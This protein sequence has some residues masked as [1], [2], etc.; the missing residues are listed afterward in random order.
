[1]PDI[2]KSD[3]SIQKARRSQRRAFSFVGNTRQT[4]T[5][6]FG[7]AL[8]EKRQSLGLTQADLAE[9]TGMSRSYISEVECGRENIS[10]ERAEKLARA[11]N[12]NLTELIKE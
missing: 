4:I 12:S 7:V 9:I 10:L 6:R 2:N 3:S 1:M 11:V 5:G 8:K